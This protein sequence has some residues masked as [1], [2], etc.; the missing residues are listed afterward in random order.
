MS[1]QGDLIARK[2]K[3]SDS[4]ALHLLLS[5]P[6]KAF[7]GGVLGMKDFPAPDNPKDLPVFR[8]YCA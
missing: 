7:R 3:S 4:Y 8:E 2:E 5:L 6:L 1:V